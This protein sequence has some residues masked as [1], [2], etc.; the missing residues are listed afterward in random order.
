MQS[1]EGGGG[2]EGGRWVGGLKKRNSSTTLAMKFFHER[3]R[4]EISKL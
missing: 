1:W 2:R 4:V 3:M